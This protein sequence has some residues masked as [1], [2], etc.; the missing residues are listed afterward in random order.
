MIFKRQLKKWLICII[1]LYP[2]NKVPMDAI[3]NA[4]VIKKQVF[5]KAQL[6]KKY[7]ILI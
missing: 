3:S 6:T 1:M 7:L 2:P 4:N 5:I